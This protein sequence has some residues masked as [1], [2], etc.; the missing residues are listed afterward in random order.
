MKKVTYLAHKKNNNRLISPMDTLRGVLDD[1]E[2]GRQSFANLIVIGCSLES[3]VS[4]MG[5]YL[6]NLSASEAVALLEISKDQFIR[7]INGNS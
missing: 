3:E 7:M 6:S 2:S 5:F 1:I 4:D